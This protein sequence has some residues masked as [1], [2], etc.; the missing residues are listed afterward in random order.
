M[1]K[2][3]IKGAG[4]RYYEHLLENRMTLEQNVRLKDGPCVA[5][6]LYLFPLH[7]NKKYVMTLK[8]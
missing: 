3:E 1:E 6:E 2:G 8:N 7:K 5:K 4:E